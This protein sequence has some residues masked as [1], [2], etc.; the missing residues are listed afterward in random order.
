MRVIGFAATLAVG[1]VGPLAG[2]LAS[3]IP[4][5]PFSADQIVV[6]NSIGSNGKMN[7]TTENV[8]VHRDASGRM[9]E[10]MNPGLPVPPPEPLVILL[11]DPVAGVMYVLETPTRTAHRMIVPP[12]SFFSSGLPSRANM[13]APQGRPEGKS[14]SLGTKVFE[15]IEA[16][17]ARS[18]VTWPG[19]A[20]P[21][22]KEIT[23]VHETWFSKEKGMILFIKNSD[24]RTGDETGKLTN[25]KWEDPDPELFIVPLGYQIVDLQEAR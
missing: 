15:G 21:D 14:E 1:F 22:G 11:R 9:W 8:Q 19:E 17:G 10:P 25:I 20:Q 12:G 7:E 6:R 16:L 3:P 18:T 5:A 13:K 23:T 4:G 24:S 2:Q